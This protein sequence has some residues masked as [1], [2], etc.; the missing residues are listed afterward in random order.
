[1]A[2]ESVVMRICIVYVMGKCAM[3]GEFKCEVECDGKVMI[4]GTTTT[5]GDRIVR[6]NGVFL[7]QTQYLCPPGPFTV[8]FSLPGPVEPNQ[9]TGTFGSD[10]ILEGI[11]MKQRHRSAAAALIFEP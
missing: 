5:G 4:K 1:M 6:P 10:G 11:V 3:A 8:S 9:F 7:M 2:L